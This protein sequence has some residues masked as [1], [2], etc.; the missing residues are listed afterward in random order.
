M[1]FQRMNTM[2]DIIAEERR[3]TFRVIRPQRDFYEWQDEQPIV[4]LTEKEI[5]YNW[6]MNELTT[7]YAA[8][9]SEKS[10]FGTVSFNVPVTECDPNL[11]EEIMAAN[12]IPLIEKKCWYNLSTNELISVRLTYDTPA[13][14][15]IHMPI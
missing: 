7:R 12:H 11:I 2:E 10:I 9:M 14:G 1:R 5:A 15:I 6:L 8:H 3:S 4:T 13:L